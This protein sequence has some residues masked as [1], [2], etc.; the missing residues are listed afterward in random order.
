MDAI[1]EILPRAANEFKNCTKDTCPVQDSVYGYY[2][3]K[4]G[5]LIFIAL[6]VTSLICHL[7]Q[8]IKWKSWTFLIGLG[9]GASGEAVGKVENVSCE[10]PSANNMQDM[11]DAFGFGVILSA[12]QSKFSINQPTHH[13]ILI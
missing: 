11:S 13:A 9:I 12:G 1:L 8:G 3:S 10:I 7:Y 6:F 2:P 4:V 5:T